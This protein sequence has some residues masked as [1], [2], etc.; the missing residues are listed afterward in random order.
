MLAQPFIYYIVPPRFLATYKGEDMH[1]TRNNSSV[2]IWQATTTLPAFPPL[3]GDVETDVCVI[4]AGIAG[5]TTA[6]LLTFL[7]SLH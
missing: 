4:G 2:S 5:F 7:L 6:Y 3:E 1:N